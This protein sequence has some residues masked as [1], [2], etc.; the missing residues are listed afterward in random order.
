MEESEIAYEYVVSNHT[1]LLL[2]NVNDP[3]PP[4]IP[5][6]INSYEFLQGMYAAV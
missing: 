4:I 3:F 2:C 1:K 6:Q 5:S